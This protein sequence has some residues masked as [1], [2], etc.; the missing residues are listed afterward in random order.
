MNN[1][2]IL[3]YKNQAFVQVNLISGLMKMPVDLTT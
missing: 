3:A 1:G 2:M